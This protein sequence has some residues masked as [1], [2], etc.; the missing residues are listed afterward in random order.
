VALVR[1][2]VD[3]GVFSANQKRQIV[4]GVTEVLVAVGDETIRET[5]CVIVDE[6]AD[7]L[8][9]TAAADAARGEENS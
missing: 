5:T 6:V 2:T 9:A 7:E 3:E 1:I 4:E 8:M